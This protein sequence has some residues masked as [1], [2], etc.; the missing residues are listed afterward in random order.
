MIQ[1][2]KLVVI[3]Q[4]I[5]QKLIRII[6]LLTPPIMLRLYRNLILKNAKNSITYEGVFLSFEDVLAKYGSQPVY[7]TPEIRSQA[8]QNVTNLKTLKENKSR[9]AP[10]WS[11]IRF[12]FLSSF[13]T[14]FKASSLCI[15][16]IGGG[17]GETYL[18]LRDSTIKDYDYHILELNETV[19]IL[20][21]IFENEVN[22]TTHTTLDTFF[23][24]PDIIYFGSSLQYFQY[25]K[26]TL[27]DVFK[28]SPEYI[29]ISDTPMAEVETFACAQV[30]MP[31]IVIPR[32]V[33]NQEEIIST[34]L[35]ENYEICHISTNY[36][37]F[38]NFDN[39]EGKY[40]NT[41]HTNLIFR[42]AKIR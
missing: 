21:S 1:K 8:I 31:G 38:H 13:I 30:N 23:M 6:L 42:K 25:Y 26:R 3:L 19:E 22:L 33:F 36:Y 20:K 27:S 17:Y 2:G 7:S 18:H 34:F 24:T 32:W 15:L 35:S 37:P 14:S 28:F 4:T 5:S 39:Y 16:D 41:F 29:V 12:N 10:T 9:V 11:S 40:Q